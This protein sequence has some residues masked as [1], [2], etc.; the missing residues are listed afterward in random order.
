MDRPNSMVMFP[1]NATSLIV[2]TGLIRAGHD[3][4][5]FCPNETHLRQA[6]SIPS[7]LKLASIGLVNV[8]VQDSVE[9]ISTMDFVIF[10]LLDLLP[11]EERPSFGR[12]CQDL[13]RY[14]L[15]INTVKEFIR[16]LLFNICLCS[17]YIAF[18]LRK[19]QSSCTHLRIIDRTHIT[20]GL[21]SHWKMQLAKLQPYPHEPPK[22]SHSPQSV[23][24]THIFYLKQKH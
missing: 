15:E 21:F 22:A 2:G 20:N 8:E 23:C 18:N 12:I 4:N 6:G 16:L 17:H 5:L 7:E 24:W 19:T 14:H 13:F 3:V 11:H 1:T 9:S 10:P